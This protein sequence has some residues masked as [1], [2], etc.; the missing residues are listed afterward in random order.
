MKEA[1]S[2]SI[3]Y[4]FKKLERNMLVNNENGIY[5]T[6][7]KCH[8]TGENMP[9]IADYQLF[10]E[11]IDYKYFKE[12]ELSHLDDWG[13]TYPRLKVWYDAL[14]HSEDESAVK[15]SKG[16]RKVIR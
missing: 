2:K 3:P 11:F 13:S 6:S 16:L 5:S 7:L 4:A 9:S 10:C 14:N 12:G 8:L 15:W 1:L